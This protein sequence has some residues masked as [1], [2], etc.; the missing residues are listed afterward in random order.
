MTACIQ[1]VLKRQFFMRQKLGNLFSK[2]DQFGPKLD[3]F[4]KLELR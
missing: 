4:S 3:L 1:T 2:L